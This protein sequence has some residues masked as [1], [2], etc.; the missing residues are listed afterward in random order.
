MELVYASDADAEQAAGYVFLDVDQD[1]E[2]GEPAEFFAGLPTQDVGL[3]YFV[4]LFLTHE[5]DPV[6]LHRRRHQ[7]RDRGR[8]RGA[9]RR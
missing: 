4:D 8:D 6:V 9:G 1:P 2:T 3:E 5:P 7:L